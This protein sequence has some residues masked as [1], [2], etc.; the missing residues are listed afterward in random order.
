MFCVK[1]N[2]VHSIN[3]YSNAL[4]CV[5]FDHLKVCE[6]KEA[7]VYFGHHFSLNLSLSLF[8]VQ[9]VEVLLLIWP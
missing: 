9:G 3:C 6:V 4:F 2:L 8:F 5:S 1:R 7:P